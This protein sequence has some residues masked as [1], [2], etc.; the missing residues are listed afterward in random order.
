MITV[1]F[2]TC[3]D[4]LLAWKLCEGRDQASLLVHWAPSSGT[5]VGTEPFI[6]ILAQQYIFVDQ[7]YE[8]KP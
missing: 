8:Q 1:I 4:P 7:E 2:V 6:S 5:M 3:L